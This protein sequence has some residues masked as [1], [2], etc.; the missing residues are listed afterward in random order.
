MPALRRCRRGGQRGCRRRAGRRCT[1]RVGHPRRGVSKPLQRLRIQTVQHPTHRSGRES[2]VRTAAAPARSLHSA[3]NAWASIRHARA[4]FVMNLTRSGT[5]A[6]AH[7]SR[8]SV[9]DLGRSMFRSTSVY[10]CA[11]RSVSH[12]T[13]PG[14]IGIRTGWSDPSPV[15]CRLVLAGAAGASAFKNAESLALRHE[16]AVL[17]RGNRKRCLCWPDRAVLLR[18]PHCC[19]GSWQATY[20]DPGHAAV[21]SVQATTLAFWTTASPTKFQTVPLHAA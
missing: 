20:R 18:W 9:H 3:P 8:S 13:C 12:R 2:P 15:R 14:M 6:P 19:Q 11:G 4:I 5:P 10:P 1:A 17:R 7:R 16:I 21:R